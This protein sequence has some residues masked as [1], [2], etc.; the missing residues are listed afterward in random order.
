MKILDY[1]D[2]KFIVT[3]IKLFDYFYSKLFVTIKLLNYFDLKLIV[4]IKLL[5]LWFKIIRHHKTIRLL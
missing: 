1:F 4:T 2:L 5:E 3:I